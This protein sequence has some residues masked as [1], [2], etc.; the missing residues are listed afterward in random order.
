LA[1]GKQRVLCWICSLHCLLT[2]DR[3]EQNILFKKKRDCLFPFGSSLQF[4]FMVTKKWM[5]SKLKNWSLPQV[6]VFLECPSKI[7]EVLVQKQISNTINKY[8]PGTIL[9][10]ILMCKI[11]KP[12]THVHSIKRIHRM[13]LV[14]H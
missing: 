7:F 10:I 8:H 3:A 13:P 2:E 4:R 5:E 9:Q 12:L 11:F 6:I 14:I 1:Q